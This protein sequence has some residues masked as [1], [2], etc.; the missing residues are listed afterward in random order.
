ML[1]TPLKDATREF[2][3]LVIEERLP[4]F[5]KKKRDKT[6]RQRNKRHGRGR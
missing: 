3:S 1:P 5:K 4:Q 2:V 6:K